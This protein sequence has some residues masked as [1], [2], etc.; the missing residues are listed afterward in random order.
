MEKPL[1]Q[2][3]AVSSGDEHQVQPSENNLGQWEYFPSEMCIVQ[4]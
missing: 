4:Y 2:C 1:V 3:F